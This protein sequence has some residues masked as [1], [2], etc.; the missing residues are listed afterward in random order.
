MKEKYKLMYSVDI[1]FPTTKDHF[2]RLEVEEAV[3]SDGRMAACDAV[4][5]VSIIRYDDRNDFAILSG[6]GEN[7]SQS[8]PVEDWFSLMVFV[9]HKLKD[10]D[11]TKLKTDELKAYQTFMEIY[12]EHNEQ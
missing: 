3:K 7:K 2:T 11:L 10:Y 5:L 8:L 12:H 1:I 6:D 9:A 4:V